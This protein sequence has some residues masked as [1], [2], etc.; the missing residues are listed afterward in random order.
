VLLKAVS[1]FLLRPI[2]GFLSWKAER[3]GS[4]F[5]FTLEKT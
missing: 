4:A 1:I 2:K 3:Y 5:F